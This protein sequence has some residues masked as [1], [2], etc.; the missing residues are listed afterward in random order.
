MTETA[1]AAPPGEAPSN[2]A[3]FRHLRAL[4][5]RW[6]GTWYYR[7]AGAELDAALQQAEAEIL[8]AFGE[9]GDALRRGK[10]DVENALRLV[11]AARRDGPDVLVA[12]VYGD[13]IPE[14]QGAALIEAASLWGETADLTV[15]GV[16]AVKTSMRGSTRGRF[17]A[18]VRVRC[19]NYPEIRR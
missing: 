10:A 12:L 8:A 15:D 11:E 14:M 3:G 6:N 16:T 2:P 19:L 4:A 18:Y 13:G 17:N 1:V 7:S 9:A 5:A